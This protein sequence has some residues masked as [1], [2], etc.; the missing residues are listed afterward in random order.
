MGEILQRV[1]KNIKTVKRQ[2]QDPRLDRRTQ[3][4]KQNV[5]KSLISRRERVLK[6]IK[7]SK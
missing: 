7:S 3:M 4:M 1:N 6:A 2:L 5:L